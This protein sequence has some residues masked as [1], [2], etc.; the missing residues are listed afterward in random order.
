MIGTIILGI[1][2]INV[3]IMKTYTR[4]LKKLL[5][6]KYIDE[7]VIGPENHSHTS[8]PLRE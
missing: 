1:E 8:S 5:I 3:N 2:K 7:S 4:D 6:G